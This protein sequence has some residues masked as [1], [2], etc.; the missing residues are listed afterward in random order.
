MP[1]RED[2]RIAA[3][4]PADCEC[5]RAARNCSATAGPRCRRRRQWRRRATP[6]R[7]PRRRGR[8]RLPCITNCPT[9]P[10][11]HNERGMLRGTAGGAWA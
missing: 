2:A 10:N 3:S 9:T 4:R 6:G 8:D 1:R 7:G 11:H 5:S